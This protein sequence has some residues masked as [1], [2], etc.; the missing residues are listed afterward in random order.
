MCIEGVGAV[1]GKRI[2]RKFKLPL[3]RIIGVT[4]CGGYRESLKNPPE[5][6]KLAGDRRR[7]I[8]LE[9]I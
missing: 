7:I 6:D 2:L 9:N 8:F 1:R 4:F 3:D 5:N